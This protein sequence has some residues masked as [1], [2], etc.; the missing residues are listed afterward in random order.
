MSHV[1][2]RSATFRPSDSDPAC[3]YTSQ[4]RFL[5]YLHSQVTEHIVHRVQSRTSSEVSYSTIIVV[6]IDPCADECLAA[7][8]N[9]T[10]ENIVVWDGTS[11]PSLPYPLH[12]F[13][14]QCHLPTETTVTREGT[15]TRSEW[16]VSVSPLQYLKCILPN[17][18]IQLGFAYARFQDCRRISSAKEERQQQQQQQ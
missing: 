12:R 8:D 1:L 3:R 4:P 6:V 5:S 15:P 13:P 17:S 16:Q 7:T 2:R 14:L 10:L 11:S 9:K 18:S